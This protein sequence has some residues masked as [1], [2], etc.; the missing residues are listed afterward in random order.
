M[1]LWTPVTACVSRDTGGCDAPVSGSRELVLVRVR[2]RDRGHE[3]RDLLVNSRPVTPGVD[4]DDRSRRRAD[5][6]R[7]QADTV[8][9]NYVKIFDTSGDRNTSRDYSRQYESPGLAGKWPLP[10]AG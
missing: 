1:G 5:T 3:P 4:G 7:I 6:V 8:G 2:T 9:Y 10:P